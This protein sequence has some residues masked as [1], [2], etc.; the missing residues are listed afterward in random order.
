[1]PDSL[2]W[3]ARSLPFVLPEPL[4]LLCHRRLIW[5]MTLVQELPCPLASSWVWPIGA[6]ARRLPGWVRS[7]YSNWVCHL[8][9]VGI[10]EDMN[11]KI[12]NKEINTIKQIKTHRDTEPGIEAAT[13]FVCLFACIGQSDIYFLWT[14]CSSL[15]PILKLVVSLFIYL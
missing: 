3:S 6:P 8:L 5:S 10:L 7:G 14:T 1:M 12:Y 2:Q 15:L 9:P 13:T 11:I 4:C